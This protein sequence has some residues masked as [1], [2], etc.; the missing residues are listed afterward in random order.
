MAQRNK[1]CIISRQ[2]QPENNSQTE[3]VKLINNLQ[4]KDF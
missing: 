3:F 2:Q 4:N 1:S